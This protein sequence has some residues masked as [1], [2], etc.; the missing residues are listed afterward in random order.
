[1]AIRALTCLHLCPYKPWNYNKVTLVWL[2]VKADT[3]QWDC[4]YLGQKRIFK[5]VQSSCWL[6]QKLKWN[7]A[8][9]WRHIKLMLNCPSKAPTSGILKLNGNQFRSMTVLI[10]G[11]CALRKHLQNRDKPVC[12]LCNEKKKPLTHVT[13]FFVS[14]CSKCLQAFFITCGCILL[15]HS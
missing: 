12:R 6:E 13:F 5:I 4:R 9:G 10:A 2:Q 11:H 1:M 15:F 7:Y 14:I 8:L 3:G